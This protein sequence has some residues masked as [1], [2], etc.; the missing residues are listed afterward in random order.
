MMKLTERIVPTLSLVLLLVAGCRGYV[1]GGDDGESDDDVIPTID[2]RATQAANAPV[3][4]ISAQIQ[5]SEAQKIDLNASFAATKSFGGWKALRRNQASNPTSRLNERFSRLNGRFSRLN[6]RFND[7]SLRKNA[8]V[9]RQLANCPD[10]GTVDIIN[11]IDT[12]TEFRLTVRFS[13]C[14][15]VDNGTGTEILSDGFADLHELLTITSS[16]ASLKDETTFEN[17]TIK[18][19]NVSSGIV[20]ENIFA[21]FEGTET[22]EINDFTAC[23]TAFEGR[24]SLTADG[25]VEISLDA[26]EDGD[27]SDSDDDDTDTSVT[28]T[29]YV[30][31]GEATGSTDSGCE[32]VDV[33]EA[34]YTTSGEASLTD[35]NNPGGS[36]IVS[37]P[38]SDPIII[39]IRKEQGG[40]SYAT[41]GTLAVSVDEP[42]I[43]ANS[44]TFRFT[45]TVR[46]FIPDSENCP[47][48]GQLMV[49][50]NNDNITIDY[51]ASGGVIVT[52]SDS[53]EEYDSC[54]E[55]EACPNA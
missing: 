1:S 6:G 46:I 11:D 37:S 9:L 20:L 19:S 29:N 23:G 50:L 2:A 7:T 32:I 51:T 12:D 33:T 39:N 35:K 4:A 45:T 16:S 27:F 38:S 55:I 34:T 31:T 40:V 42:C 47:T 3:K 25:T 22:V 13:E 26:N 18:T 10:G 36:F 14:R 54:D 53:M 49:T 28:F 52:T 43:E 48:A 44:L 5:A 30:Y 17:L 8:F 41:D 24:V 15:I 21:N